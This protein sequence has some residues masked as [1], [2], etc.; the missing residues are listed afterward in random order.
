[1]ERP[2]RRVIE[3]SLHVLLVQRRRRQALG[4]QPIDHRPLAAV[5][6]TADSQRARRTEGGREGGHPRGILQRRGESR[7]PLAVEQRIEAQANHPLAAVV[8]GSRN[9]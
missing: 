4:E 8:S 5:I 7:D 2:T 9:R 6:R 1:M 3:R